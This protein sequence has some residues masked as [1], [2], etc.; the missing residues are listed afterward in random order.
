[1][2]DKQPECEENTGEEVG[3]QVEALMVDWIDQSLAG[4]ER[5][6]LVSQVL[7]DRMGDIRVNVDALMGRL[8]A[9]LQ[10]EIRRRIREERPSES[11]GTP[12]EE[13][14]EKPRE[15]VRF[16]L[17][18]R[19][20]HVVLFTSCIVLILTGLP[21]KFFD[22]AWAAFM[23]GLMGGIETSSFMAISGSLNELKGL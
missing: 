2:A 13:V 14:E 8:S 21:I 1:M 5:R 15:F 7:E 11:G 10:T 19:I 6:D 12:Q 23:F 22:T 18:F 16:N 4:E 3:R 9:E 17:N 20:Q